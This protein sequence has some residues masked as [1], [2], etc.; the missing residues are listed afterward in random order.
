MTTAD[1]LFDPLVPNR[2]WFAEGLGVWYADGVN[3]GTQLI[4]H[5]R[6]VG[7]EELVSNTA[8]HPPGG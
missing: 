2:L 4:W 5:S 7:I 8:V 3:T 6:S 1:I